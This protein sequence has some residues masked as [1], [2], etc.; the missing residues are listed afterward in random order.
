MNCQIIVAIN[1]I[2]KVNA[3]QIK[4]VK[5]ELLKY[6]LIPEENGGD[7]QVVPISALKKTNLDL[8]KEEIWTKAEIMDLKGDPKGF[9]E[10]Y[11]IESTQDLHKGKL[12]TVLIQRGTLR[13]GDFLVAG[14]TWCKVKSILDENSKSLTSASLSQAVQVMGWKDLPAAGDEVYQ[15]ESESKLKELID[16][17]SEIQEIRKLKV[18]SDSIKKK[19]ANEKEIYQ[20][21]RKKRLLKGGAFISDF[22]TD[23]YIKRDKLNEKEIIAKNRSILTENKREGVSIILKTD[24][25][26]SLEAILD[27][28]DTYDQQD[29]VNLDL[30]H[31]EVG[32]VK[33]SDIEMASTFGAII[34][35]FNLSP[36][37]IEADYIGKTEANGCKIKHFN[38]IYKMF[39]DLLEEINKLAPVIDVKNTLGEAKVVQLFDFTEDKKKLKVIGGLCVDGVLQSKANFMIM[40]NEK[41]IAEDLKCKSLKNVK[42]DVTQVK[43]NVNFGLSLEN[44]NVSPEPGDKIIC[45]NI[46]KVK[47]NIKWDL[48]F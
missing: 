5:G 32:Q 21:A 33:Q 42:T 34:Y 30:I 40:R 18:D 38:V 16:I 37:S 36:T 3:E 48:G 20:E 9:V 44:E 41:V 13:K 7:V 17:R 27:V 31:F 26:G 14:N 23:R 12:A 2:D 6:D 47:Q 1:K 24:V 22:Y 15:V 25:N 28:L 19:R 39:D 45:Y 4:K 35:C 8:L 43:K 46:E 10:G 29:K 11:V